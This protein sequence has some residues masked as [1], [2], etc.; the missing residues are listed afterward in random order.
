[1]RSNIGTLVLATSQVRVV[2]VILHPDT[3]ESRS[4]KVSALHKETS[5]ILLVEEERCLIL[6]V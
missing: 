6:S 2:K 5:G 1:V 4:S 3:A